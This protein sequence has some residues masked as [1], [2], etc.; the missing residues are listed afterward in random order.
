MTHSLYSTELID[1]KR[2]PIFFGKGR[3]TQRYEDPKYKF[4]DKLATDMW[5]LHW[6]PE[7][8]DLTKDNIDYNNSPTHETH[9][10]TSNI[11]SQIFNDSLQ[12]RALMQTFGQICTNPEVEDCLNKISC[13]EGVHSRSYTHILRNLF[14]KPEVIFDEMVNDPMIQKRGRTMTYYYDEFYNNIIA[15]QKMSIDGV[16]HSDEFMKKIKVST[17]LALINLNILEG[18]RFFISF[19]CS[20]AFAENQKMEGN[21]KEIKLIARDELKH[22]AFSQ[23]LINILKKESE[24]GFTH[25]I[26][27]LDNIVYN[28]YKEACEEEFEW[29]DY[30]FKDGSIIGLNAVLLKKYIKYLANSR[31]HAIGYKAIYEKTENPLSWMDHWLSSSNIEVAPMETEISS[32][33]IGALDKQININAFEV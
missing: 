2:E 7:E 12:G 19:A 27:E 18:I 3:G 21:A 20:F 24:E 28:M 1:F 5:K 15:Y 31:L 11:K 23:K 6:T 4:F 22:L 25:I 30:L 8:F 10:F 29:A 14:S 16:E 17:Y 32:Y 26:P 13:F 33:L 9:L